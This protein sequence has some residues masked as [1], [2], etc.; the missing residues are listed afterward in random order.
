MNGASE[1]TLQELLTVAKAMNINLTN[2]V[3]SAGSGGGNSGAGGIASTA[4]SVASSFNIAGL[5][6]KA[7]GGAFSLL[8][9]IVGGI[10]GTVTDLAG[11]FIAFSKSAMAG[12]ASLSDLAKVF[13]DLPIVGR[14]AGL[15]GEIF[16]YADNLAV[17]YRS[18]TKAGASFG[19]D[20]FAM[21]T[22]A[23]KSGLSLKAFSEI[24]S[25][26]GELFATMGLNVQDGIDKF[27]QSSGALLGPGSKFSKM[28]FGLGY[29]ADQAGDALATVIGQQGS[30]GR[31][32]SLTADQLAEKTKDYLVELDAL[33]KLTGM[34]R[35]E[36]E[37]LQKAA[38][39]DQAFQTFK[40]R[41]D[42][43]GLATMN[44]L[45]QTGKAFG[46][47]VMDAIKFGATG[48]IAPWTKAGED[49]NT[50]SRG[51]YGEIAK[52]TR[53]LVKSGVPVE[54]ARRIIMD[55]IGKSSLSIENYT[56][57]MNDAQLS[58]NS[59]MINN[60][61]E[62]ARF[63]RALKDSGG[64]VN[65]A[66][67]K[68]KKQQ[69]DQANGNAS[70]LG[71]ANQSI[72]NFGAGLT[73]MMNKV[74]GP[75]TT[76]LL[77]YTETFIAG[78]A[79]LTADGGPLSGMLDGLIKSFGDVTGWFGKT[80]EALGNTKTPKEFFDTLST[81]ATEAWNNIK[82][83][84]KEFMDGPVGT[85]ITEFWTKDIKPAIMSLWDDVKKGMGSVFRDI[86]DFIVKE[87]RNTT[88]GRMLFGSGSKEEQAERELKDAVT[89]LAENQ[90]VLADKSSSW[91]DRKIAENDVK[92]YTR[93]IEDIKKEGLVKDKDF[94]DI[95]NP[96]IPQP[97]A[98][99]GPI[100]AG[101]YLVGEAG[102]ELLNV[103]ASGNVVSNDS[104]AAL[105][106]RT[107][108]SD[109]AIAGLMNMLNTQNK[110]MLSY[111]AEMTDYTKRNNDAL[112]GMSGD[113]FA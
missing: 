70:A 26:N 95:V 54:E 44:A 31:K 22:A 19:G 85:A 21:S 17:F 93:Q 75:L 84:Y 83:T 99:G 9:N 67:A 106:A 91:L 50:A 61:S 55:K 66:L 112:K 6:G 51:M 82:K 86:L 72:Q 34:S 7:V 104:I 42:E 27:T 35:E 25:R 105:L 13:K 80:F 15:I 14:F 111:I 59:G 97:K 81:K 101:S 11:N 49:L 63:G 69:E 20:L 78:A 46:P 30:M 109:K 71:Q 56:G 98:K 94:K 47:G 39:Q 33:T 38:N 40:S 79:K 88:F 108:E 87:S 76:K 77:G 64:D 24:V 58:V 60:V 5:A 90:K 73:T 1:A 65:V 100:N 37:K 102:P 4:A 74:L 57:K 32:N 103:G 68:I 18:M 8:G 52:T 12:T 2:L 107:G 53:D 29:T 36:A 62:M 96:V 41:L 113:A 43:R 16:D 48:V 10:V 28:I 89:K 23:A 110:Q 3:K 45:E 92:A